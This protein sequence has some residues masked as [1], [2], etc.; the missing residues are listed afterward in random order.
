ML[1]DFRTQKTQIGQYISTRLGV[2]A[3]AENLQAG[4]A[5]FS[6][7]GDVYGDIWGTGSGHGW[8]SAYIAGEPLRQY[9]TMVGV[10]GRPKQ[11]HL[12]FMMMVL[13]YSLP[14]LTC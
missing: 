1:L 8:L 11:S 2:I 6:K 7:A 14:Q 5:I 10:P 9:I 4:N 12:C 13:V 3:A